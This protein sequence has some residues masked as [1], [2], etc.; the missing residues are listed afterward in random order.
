MLQLG[1]HVFHD[2]LGEVRDAV[3][4]RQQVVRQRVRQFTVVDGLLEQFLL[5]CKVVDV[6][7]DDQPRRQ[8]VEFEDFYLNF[9][10]KVAVVVLSAIVILARPFAFERIRLK[11]G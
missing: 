4:R 8:A 10:H 5:F 7:N 6:A 11:A 3:E 2:V 1:F 9:H